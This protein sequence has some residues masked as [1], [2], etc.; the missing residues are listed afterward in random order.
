MLASPEIQTAPCSFHHP[1]IKSLVNRTLVQ[2]AYNLCDPDSL[3]KKIR[4]IIT[5]LGQFRQFAGSTRFQIENRNRGSTFLKNRVPR[6]HRFW[7]RDLQIPDSQSRLSWFWGPTRLQLKYLVVW[8][9]TLRAESHRLQS[10][11]PILFH[12][13]PTK[14]NS[15]L[16]RTCEGAT[17]NWCK[18]QCLCI[19][20]C[21][22]MHCV[23]LN[24]L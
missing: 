19:V 7:N 4:H 2:R 13:P 10:K 23:S 12:E 8:A 3:P 6:K 21:T 5:R 11:Y 9:P 17:H 24:C 20:V 16:Q 15:R 14:C 18:P 1:S 22:C